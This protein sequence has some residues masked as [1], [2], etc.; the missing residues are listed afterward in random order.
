MRSIT[1]VL[2]A[3]SLAAVPAVA[4]KHELSFSVGAQVP[5]NATFNTGTGFAL[6]GSYAGRLARVPFG[7]LYFEVPV[8]GG[9]KSNGS[10]PSAGIT[11]Q[12]FSSFFVAPGLRLK[13]A[14]G[15]PVSPYFAAGVGLAHFRLDG[16]GFIPA[17]SHNS[18][19]V[20]MAAG[21]DFKIAPHL[22]A[23]GEVR[24][25]WSGNP[26]KDLASGLPGVADRQ[27]N[28]IP[29]VGLVVRF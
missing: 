19:V 3:L 18:T 20:D 8:A 29:S 7:S 21:V 15:L 26:F 16:N 4:Q 12:D 13:L 14:P 1:I 24:D 23:R 11:N 22:S 27:H 10:W 6:A 9:L 5:V 25:F 17:S 2:L 28:V